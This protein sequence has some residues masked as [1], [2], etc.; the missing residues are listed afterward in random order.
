MVNETSKQEEPGVLNV[1]ETSSA[2]PAVVRTILCTSN[3]GTTC[4]DMIIGGLFTHVYGTKAN[5]LAKLT[6]VGGETTVEELLDV[7]DSGIIMS[8]SHYSMREHSP[9]VVAGMFGPEDR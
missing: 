1:N 6:R 9:L 2:T 8:V 5:G 7:R 4:D 3:N